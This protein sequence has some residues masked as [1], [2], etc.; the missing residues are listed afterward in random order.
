MPGQGNILVAVYRPNPGLLERQ[1]SSIRRQSVATWV[2]HVGID[3]Y[4]PRANELVRRL[5]VDDNRFVIHHFES[6]VG[7]YRNFERLVARADSDARWIALADQ[8]DDWDLDKLRIVLGALT[9]P[10]VLLACGQA[11][12]VDID[13]RGGAATRRRWVPLLSLMFDN[14]V[15]GSITAFRPEVARGALPFPPPTAASY[16]DHWIGV[17]AAAMG[18]YRIL[19]D[20]VQSYVQHGEN[21][22]GEEQGPRLAGRLNRLWAGGG[23]VRVLAEERWGWRQSMASELLERG[24]VS[25]SDQVLVDIALARPTLRVASSLVGAVT[26][27]QVGVGRAVALGAGALLARGRRRSDRW[28]RPLGLH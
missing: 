1:I 20:V 13:G 4:D 25:P 26:A 24:L 28:T 19:E 17:V 21:V 6:N 10:D 14:Q 22:L 7:F 9:A 5:T 27:R 16:H 15:T 23:W 3:G 2:C 11:R 18:N 8:D 12:V